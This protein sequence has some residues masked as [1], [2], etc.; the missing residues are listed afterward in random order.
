MGEEYREG[1]SYVIEKADRHTAGIFECS[2][3]NGS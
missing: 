3:N 1:N 2:A